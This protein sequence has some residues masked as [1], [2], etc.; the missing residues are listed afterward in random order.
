MLDVDLDAAGDDVRAIP[1]GSSGPSAESFAVVEAGSYGFGAA[2][3]GAVF[4]RHGVDWLA[5]DQSLAEAVP[6]RRRGIETPNPG[7][8]ELAPERRR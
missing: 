6:P 3:I 5:V 2:E 1:S 8:C 4:T 7:L